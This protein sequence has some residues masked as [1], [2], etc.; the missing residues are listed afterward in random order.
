V[1][2]LST[3]ELL[4]L[5]LLGESSIDVQFQLWLTITFATIIAGFAARRLLTQPLR[6]ALTVL[7]L[8]A[9][10]VVASRWYYDAQDIFTY[11]KLLEQAGFDAQPPVVTIASRV[12]LMFVGTLA[13]I[14][15]L[16]TNSTDDEP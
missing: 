1:D 10:F 11:R 12:L 15:F 13:A 7:Y 14:Y 9:T 4:E 2:Q 6:W 5:I 8:L 3:G 16:H